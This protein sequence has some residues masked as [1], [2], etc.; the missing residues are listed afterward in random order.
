MI[1]TNISSSINAV[2]AKVELFSG[3]TLV[4]TCSCADVLQGFT[5]NR[6][7]VSNKFFGYGICYSLDMELIDM[8]NTLNLSTID[9]IKIS[10]SSNDIDFIAPYPTFVNIK[11]ARNESENVI[12]IT[13]FDLL[14]PANKHTVAELSLSAYTVREFATACAEL[15]G[16]A[17]IKIINVSDI[18]SAFDVEYSTGANFDGTEGIRAA[19]NAIAE[20]TQTIYYID[21]ENYLVFKRLDIEGAPVLSINKDDY[22][23]LIAGEPRTLGAICSATELGDNIEVKLPDV[24]GITQYIRDNPFLELLDGSIVADKLNA[25]LEAIGGFSLYQFYADWVGNYLLEI[26]DKIELER[27]NGAKISTYLLIDTITYDGSINEITEWEYKEGENETEASPAHLD[28]V[29]NQTFAKVDKVNREII[30]MASQVQGNTSE[31]SNLQIT[32]K[33]INATVKATEERIDN[34]IEGMEAELD[35]L[36]KEVALKIGADALQIE[37]ERSLENGVGK[38]KTATGYTFDEKGLSISKS[39]SEINTQITENGMKIYKGAEEVLVADNEG[40]KAEDLHATT[41]LIIGANSRFEDY[42]AAGEFRTGCFW[43]G[44]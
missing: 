22:F 12:K 14:E 15:I 19:L 7:G 13:G 38:V 10:Y 36:S 35:I 42:E 40:V 18:N 20:I 25:A 39:D 9:S 37:I 4:Q 16:A 24:E 43:I 33:G 26:G 8:D 29:L 11:S 28:E 27:E 31:I 6:A 23:E 3:S 1:N 32:T 44:S 34:N 41:F 21:N 2:K 30:I 17:G 5:V